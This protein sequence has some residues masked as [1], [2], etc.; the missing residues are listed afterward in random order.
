MKKQNVNKAIQVALV[1]DDPGVRANL[2]AMLNSSPGFQ[3]QAAYPDGLAAL[4][5]IPANRPD[6]VL[7][8]I[9]L[10]GML[11]PE[12]VRRL[13]GAAPNLPVLMLT[14]YD[15]SEQVFKSLMAGA[16]GYLLKRTSKD[17]LLEAIREVNSGGAPMSRQIARRVVQYFQE[18]KQVPEATR[19]APEVETLTNRE[20]QVLAHLA[21]GHAYKEIADLMGISFETVRTHARTIYEKL[22]VHSRTEATLKYLGK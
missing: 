14:V 8:D 19:R 1:E 5:S 16:T 10:P 12:C 4:K 11:G 3:C 15:D 7:M 13:K 20:D 2:A 17:K 18:L 9:N 22:H 6:V 21:K